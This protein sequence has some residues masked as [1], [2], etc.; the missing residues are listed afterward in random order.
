M[1]HRRRGCLHQAPRN[2]GAFVRCGPACRKQRRAFELFR[3]PRCSLPPLQ[4]PFRPWHRVSCCLCSPSLELAAFPASAAC[5]DTLASPPCCY[6]P[7][8]FFFGSRVSFDVSGCPRCTHSG[9]RHI[10]RPIVFCGTTA[11]K[12]SSKALLLCCQRSTRRVRLTFG[13]SSPA[14]F[15]AS[16]AT[17]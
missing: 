5:I 14:P 16:P 15:P 3:P 4:P 8:V 6:P 11:C 17:S 13:L 2:V 1:V 10:F 7:R 9:Y 12:S